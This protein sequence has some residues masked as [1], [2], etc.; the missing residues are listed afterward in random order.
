MKRAFSPSLAVTEVH[1]GYNRGKGWEMV[2]VCCR[3][4]E[5]RC[6]LDIKKI[7]LAELNLPYRYPQAIKK[8][9][10]HP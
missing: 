5:N 6:Q 10:Q 1:S 3:L 4:S 2:P 8:N 9:P 7:N